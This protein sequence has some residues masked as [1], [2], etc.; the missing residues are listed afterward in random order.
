MQLVGYPVSLFLERLVLFALGAG[1]GIHLV[2]LVRVQG[3]DFILFRVEILLEA[4]PLGMALAV[5][6]Y[7]KTHGRSPVPEVNVCIHGFS[8]FTRYPLERLADY[9]RP[10]MPDVQRLCDIR[11]AVVYNDGLGSFRLRH[12]GVLVRD[13]LVH[14]TNEVLV[15]ESHIDK[16]GLDRLNDFEYALLLQRLGDLLGDH[17][18]RFL[19]QLRSGERAVALELAQIHS[20][21]DGDASQ[22]R[23]IAAGL[24]RLRDI[25]RQD[26]CYLSHILAPYFRKCRVKRLNFII[27]YLSRF[28]KPKIKSF[29]C[30]DT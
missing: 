6:G 25:R 8:H 4:R 30:A 15:C 2:E 21:R 28:C 16:A 19:I 1:I 17:D 10:E 26:R 5:L 18:R 29:P 22:R 20:V 9:R 3:G 13:Y 7:H 11:R 23:I 12:A 24:E 14:I 27:A